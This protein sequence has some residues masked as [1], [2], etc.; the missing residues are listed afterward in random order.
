MGREYNEAAFYH[1][2]AHTRANKLYFSQILQGQKTNRVYHGPNECKSRGNSEARYFGSATRS[3]RPQARRVLLEDISTEGS[4]WKCSMAIR[5]IEQD[6][7][8]DAWREVDQEAWDDDD[9]PHT[10]TDPSHQSNLEVDLIDLVVPHRHH[11]G[12]FRVFS[13]SDPKVLTNEI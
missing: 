3:H 8:E 1:D 10:T 4:S 7:V 12:T 13:P 2:D 11:R 9:R 6:L 5:E